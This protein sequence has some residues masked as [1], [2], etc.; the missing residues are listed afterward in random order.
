M[1]DPC[2]RLFGPPPQRV[3][4]NRLIITALKSWGTRIRSDSIVTEK[5]VELQYAQ[6]MAEGLSLLAML[7]ALPAPLPLCTQEVDT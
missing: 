4:T 3:G 5:G 7:V 2:E 1:Q 6:T